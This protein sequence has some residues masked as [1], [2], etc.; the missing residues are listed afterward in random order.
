MSTC[1]TL[2][3][4]VSPFIVCWAT[5]SR[6]KGTCRRNVNLCRTVSTWAAGLMSA[7]PGETDLE[8]GI[9]DWQLLLQIDSD[10]SLGTMW[11]DAGRIYFW[12]REQDLKNRDFAKVL[13]VLQ[14]Y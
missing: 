9:T 4:D 8:K 7:K 12:I 14:C 6:S 3:T 13:L 1:W 11:G 5:R 2:W 10:D